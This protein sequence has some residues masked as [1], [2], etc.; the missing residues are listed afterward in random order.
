M[1]GEFLT[2]RDMWA[3]QRELG[4]AQARDEALAKELAE[5]RTSLSRLS[6]EIGAHE[7]R[8]IAQMGSLRAE[9]ITEADRAA[10]K[11]HSELRDLSAKV[12][13][14]GRQSSRLLL[15]VAAIAGAA[16]GLEG[17]SKLGLL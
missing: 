13:E 8:M 7:G 1:S 5:I 4:I 10:H 3:I 17:L 6:S 11:M 14:Q 12:D 15:I 9:L 2:S 16:L